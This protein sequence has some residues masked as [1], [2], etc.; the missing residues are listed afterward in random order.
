MLIL[1]V[2]LLALGFWSK[3]TNNAIM[4]F[5]VENFELSSVIAFIII[6]LV[7]ILSYILSTLFFK[8]KY[9]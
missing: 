1:L 7:C 5:I 3:M 9:V 8:K 6:L 2:A 4:N